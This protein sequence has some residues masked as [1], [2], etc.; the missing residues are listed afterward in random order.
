MSHRLGRG[1]YLVGTADSQG[2]ELRTHMFPATNSHTCIHMHLHMC[3]ACV[4]VV[5]GDGRLRTFR[6]KSLPSLE[7]YLLILHS[8]GLGFLPYCFF[9]SP[10]VAVDFSASVSL[11][12]SPLRSV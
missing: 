10:V 1:L 5:G 4:S 7:G 6:F 3:C 2:R 12:F 11:A 8:V 9:P